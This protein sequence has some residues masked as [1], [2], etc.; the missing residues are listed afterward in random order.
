MLNTHENI[1]GARPNGD[2][3]TLYFFAGIQDTMLGADRS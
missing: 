3:L 2:R 1:I